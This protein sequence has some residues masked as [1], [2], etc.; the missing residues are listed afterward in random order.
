MVAVPDLMALAS[1]IV[2]DSLDAA[3]RYATMQMMFGGQLNA[4]D[5]HNTGFYFEYLEEL[6]LE[7]HFC[8]IRRVSDFGLF[9]D[10]SDLTHQVRDMLL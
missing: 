6:L 5:Y 8:D 2:D 4:Y 7:F 1:L 10:S 3:A 9:L